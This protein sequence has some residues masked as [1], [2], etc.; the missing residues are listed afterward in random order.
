M[1]AFSSSWTARDTN[2]GAVLKGFMIGKRVPIVRT[3]ASRKISI[4]VLPGELADQ[5]N[6][7]T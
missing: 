5:V 3:I 1:R 2:K 6:L 7:A 4:A